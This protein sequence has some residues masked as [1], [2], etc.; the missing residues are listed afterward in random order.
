MSKSYSRLLVSMNQKA[1]TDGNHVVLYD[2]TLTQRQAR[3]PRLFAVSDFEASMMCNCTID[4]SSLCMSHA[5]S[6]KKR[7]CSFRMP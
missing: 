1:S 7:T 2:T 4:R 3:N 6:F 5:I